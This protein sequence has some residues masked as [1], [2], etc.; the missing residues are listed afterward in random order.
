MIGLIQGLLGWGDL[1]ARAGLTLGLFLALTRLAFGRR[2][3]LWQVATIIG[4]VGLLQLLDQGTLLGL[5]SQLVSALM[6]GSHGGSTN[7]FMNTG[8]H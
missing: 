8:G 6:S 2:G 5:I 1:F 7:G 4:A 3:A